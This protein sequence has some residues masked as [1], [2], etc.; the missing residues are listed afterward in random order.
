LVGG[1][2]REEGGGRREE[3][4]GGRAEAW[5]EDDLTER[6]RGSGRGG[7]GSGNDK[8][9]R[10]ERGHVMRCASRFEEEERG[11]EDEVLGAPKLMGKCCGE[12]DEVAREREIDK[13]DWL[14]PSKKFRAVPER[15]VTCA[16]S[17][18]HASVCVCTFTFAG[19][20]PTLTQS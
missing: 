19:H 3:G 10:S 9:G 8:Q 16:S 15:K 12:E 6:E 13:D 2:R 4:R 18:P 14:R 1:G 20:G 17:R 7:I 5:V 11:Q